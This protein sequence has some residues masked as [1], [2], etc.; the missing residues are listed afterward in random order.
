MSYN[1][2]WNSVPNKGGGTLTP[3]SEKWKRY[4]VIGG[5]VFVV[6]VGGIIILQ[7]KLNPVNKLMKLKELEML[8]NGIDR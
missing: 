1:P 3:V 2:E 5:I 7:Q 8:K 6:I 4:L